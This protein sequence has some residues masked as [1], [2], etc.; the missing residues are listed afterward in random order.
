MG[1][2]LQN[3]FNHLNWISV[4]QDIFKI[5]RGAQSEIQ[6]ANIWNSTK[7]LKT[8]INSDFNE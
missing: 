3:I 6:S 4:A 8:Q 7:Y 2:D 1:L 5:L